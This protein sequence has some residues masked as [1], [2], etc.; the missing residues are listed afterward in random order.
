M[1]KTIPLTNGQLAIVHESVFDDVNRYQ[2]FAHKIDNT[3]YACRHNTQSKGERSEYIYMHRFI[4]KLIHGEIKNL[5]IEHIDS[6]GLNNDHI[7]NLKTSEQNPDIQQNR[8]K[9]KGAK[10]QHKGITWSSYYDKWKA[11]IRANGK[12]HSLGYRKYEKDAALLYD[13]AAKYYY[14]EPA[15]L[16]FPEIET[17]KYKPKKAAS[18]FRGVSLRKKDQKWIANIRINKKLKFLGSFD[19]QESAAAAYDREAIKEWGNDAETN[20]PK[21]NYKDES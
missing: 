18:K 1:T 11:E 19:T 2:W 7:T 9:R 20:F 3:Y 16:N 5:R 10:S 4:W 12:K 6:N 17:E 13:S 14:G 8:K 15:Y 21:E